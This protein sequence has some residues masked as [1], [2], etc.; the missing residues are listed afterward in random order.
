MKKTT[1]KFYDMFGMHG[2]LFEMGDRYMDVQERTYPNGDPSLLLPDVTGLIV[3]PVYYNDSG[4][5]A[6]ILECDPDLLLPH[7]PGLF[8][9]AAAMPFKD[10]YV[11][12]GEHASE[13]FSH[14][15]RADAEKWIQVVRNISD[16]GSSI[17]MVRVGINCEAAA[18]GYYELTVTKEDY[19]KLLEGDTSP[20][21]HLLDK[22]VNDA[23][24]D[25][26][27]ETDYTVFNMDTNHQ[28]V[29]WR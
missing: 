15:K 12:F 22:T 11:E 10:G 26:D 5:Y 24:R 27:F 7:R 21:E 28:V 6:G 20:I 9:T 23:V 1:Q 13:L 18:R 14:L 29:D 2:I 25:K 16:S 8:F 17:D 19:E 3:S 4:K